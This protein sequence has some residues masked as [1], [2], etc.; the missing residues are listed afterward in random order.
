MRRVFLT[1]SLGILA[2]VGSALANDEEGEAD[3]TFTGAVTRELKGK[4]VR[5]GASS[6]K[7]GQEGGSWRV[8]EDGFEFQ[9]VALNERELEKPSVILNLKGPPKVSYAWGKRKGTVAARKDR[10]VVELDTELR[11]VFG[12]EIVRVKGTMRCPPRAP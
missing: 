5:C 9:V 1:L 11:N 6:R 2:S 8:L 3:L 10:T 12:K 4:V 7:D